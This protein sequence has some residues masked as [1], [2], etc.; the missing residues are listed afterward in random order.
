MMENLSYWQKFK[1][2]GV[3]LKATKSKS[4]KIFWIW[5]G[6]QTIKGSLTTSLIWIP[7]LYAYFHHTN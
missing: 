7:M 4:K 6:Y 5:I 3:R 2:L 1:A